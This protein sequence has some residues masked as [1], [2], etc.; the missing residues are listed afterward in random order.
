MRRYPLGRQHLK[1]PPRNGVVDL[2]FAAYLPALLRV[3]GGRIVFELD[4]EALRV[5]RRVDPFGF[6]LVAQLRLLNVWTLSVKFHI[7]TIT[8]R[9]GRGSARVKK[10][11]LAPYP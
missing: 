5:A 7:A 6:A 3:K 10:E 4:D 2:A 8:G 9:L 1:K 11:L